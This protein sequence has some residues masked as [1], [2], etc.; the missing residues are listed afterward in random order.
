MK[1]L[2]R[3]RAWKKALILPKINQIGELISGRSSRIKITY[4]KDKLNEVVPGTIEVQE[5]MMKLFDEIKQS[6]DE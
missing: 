3:K 5:E 1:V 4:L 2:K 6:E